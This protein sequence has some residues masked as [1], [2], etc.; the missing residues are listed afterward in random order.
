MLGFV[1]RVSTQKELKMR[2]RKPKEFTINRSK[3]VQGGG[4][5]NISILGFSELLN[6][7]GNM[8]CLGFYSE[9]C[10][11]PRKELKGRHSPANV[12][13]RNNNIQIPYMAKKGIKLHKSKMFCFNDTSFAEELMRLNDNS[14]ATVE[15]IRKRDKEKV[16]KE[17]F[18]LIGVKV[19]FVGQY[20][21]G[22]I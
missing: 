17:K 18:S 12:T 3:W 13:T 2:L 19:K 16:L 6:K 11:V 14:T 21:K 15:N 10:G 1:S 4:R 9:A 8:C 20:L 22:V 7:K 5:D